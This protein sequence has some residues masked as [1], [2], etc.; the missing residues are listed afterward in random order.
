MIVFNAKKNMK[1]S[2]YCN[3]AAA[4]RASF[5]PVIASFE[6]ILDNEADV[7]VKI[8]ATIL[9]K[10]WKTSSSRVLSHVR[11]RFQIFIIRSVSLFLRGSRTKWRGAGFVDHTAIPMNPLNID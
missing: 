5:T 2:K 11:A 6:A 10:K 3:A 4:Q 9:S 1:N 8:L 7:Y